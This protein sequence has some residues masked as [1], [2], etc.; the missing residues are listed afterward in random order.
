MQKKFVRL[1]HQVL[2]FGLR[3]Q[4]FGRSVRELRD[5]TKVLGFVKVLVDKAL[6]HFFEGFIF[7]QPGQN[8][9]LGLLEQRFTALEFP[10]VLDLL[11]VWLLLFAVHN[12]KHLYVMKLFQL[13]NFYSSLVEQIAKLILW[14]HLFW[15]ILTHGRSHRVFQSVLLAFGKR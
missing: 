7:L 5:M 10:E 2:L 13:A 3:V 4:T 12:W 14:Q 15:L 9:R 1:V 6:L 11:Y 8:I